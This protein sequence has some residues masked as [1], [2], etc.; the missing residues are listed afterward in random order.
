MNE[1]VKVAAIINATK[2][3]V[4]DYYTNPK[5]IVNW[6]FADPSWHCPSA[7]N[8]MEIGGTYKARMEAKDGSFGFDFEAIYTEIAHGNS[9]TYEFGGRTVNVTVKQLDNQ[10]EII[11]EFDPENE[12]PIELQKG[13]WQ[14]ILNNFKNYTENN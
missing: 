14:S 5:H 2:E 11:V 13:G 1:K 7:I 3:K 8:E 12:N 4:W 9:F 10:T 6:N